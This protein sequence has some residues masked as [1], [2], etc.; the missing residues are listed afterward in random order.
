M[1]RIFARLQCDERVGGGRWYVGHSGSPRFRRQG[2]RLHVRDRRNP[3]ESTRVVA[4]KGP[5]RP[6]VVGPIVLSVIRG[7]HVDCLRM[8]TFVFRFSSR[9]AAWCTLLVTV[10]QA[11]CFF[12]LS[13]RG[14]H[15]ASFQHGGRGGR[16]IDVQVRVAAACGAAS[17]PVSR[18]SAISMKGFGKS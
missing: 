12:S 8:G 18:R 14:G 15:F 9:R 6:A 2:E 3:F 4:W 17:G 11:F 13:C 5:V 10:P 16:A 7:G 1:W